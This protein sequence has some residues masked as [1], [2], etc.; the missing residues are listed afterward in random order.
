MATKKAITPVVD[1]EDA[2]VTAA[3]SEVDTSPAA[4]RR[5]PLAVTALI[6]GGVICAGALFGGGVVV[7]TLI[8]S[9]TPQGQFGPGAQIPN[10]DGE[11]PP[12]P[13]GMPE[14]PGRPGQSAP[15]GDDS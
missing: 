7:G 10:F 2:R 12:M 14:M 5:S 9:Q 4:R 8:P 15:N 11:R 13:D 6:V 1:G 3:P